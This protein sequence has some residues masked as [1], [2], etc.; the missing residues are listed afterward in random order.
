M[1]EPVSRPSEEALGNEHIAR[2]WLADNIIGTSF[3]G[4]SGTITMVCVGKNQQVYAGPKFS[5][6]SHA[7]FGTR[8]SWHIPV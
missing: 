7:E 3:Y 2:R 5:S 1:R 8:Y 4:L 6:P